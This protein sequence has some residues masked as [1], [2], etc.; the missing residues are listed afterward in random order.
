MTTKEHNPIQKS[1]GGPTQPATTDV[2]QHDVS[3]T[4]ATLMFGDETIFSNLFFTIP[5]GL[6]TCILGPSGIGKTTLLRMI[7]SLAVLKPPGRVAWESDEPLARHIAY[8]AQ[9]DL[10]MPW[11]DVEANINL[12][13]RLRGQSTNSREIDV[14]LERIGLGGMGH[15]KVDSLSGGQRQRV[16]LAR[17]L[18]ENRPVVLMDEPFSALDTIT[19]TRLQDLAAE[20]L[21]GRTV[22]LVTHDPMEALRLGDNIHVMAGAPAKI[23]DALSPA[24]PSPRPLNDAGILQLQGN[25][26][27]ELSAA[28]TIDERAA[29]R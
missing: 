20:L 24:G 13:K 2:K 28:A 10:L 3:I 22:L 9:D 5:A 12:G 4:D 17:T 6:W 27:A 11:L 29:D 25:L 15:R 18:M 14:M 1:H 26:L 23:G 16:A 8:M 21:R 19:R 7:A